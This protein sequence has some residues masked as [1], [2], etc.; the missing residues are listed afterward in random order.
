MIAIIVTDCASCPFVI[1]TIDGDPW[2]CDVAGFHT[3]GNPRQLPDQRTGHRDPPP[4]PDWCPLR[5]NDRLVT[6][7]RPR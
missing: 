6:L 4:P 7:R 5:E 2:L 1:D 3:D